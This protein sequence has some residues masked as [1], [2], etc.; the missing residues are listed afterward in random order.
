MSISAPRMKI[1]THWP[2]PYRAAGY[3]LSAGVVAAAMWGYDQ[4]RVP[5]FAPVG[6]KEQIA[7]LKEQ[8][9]KLTAERDQYSSTANA[10]ESRQ[11]MDQSEQHQLETQMKSLENENNK[12]KEDLAFFES[13][14]PV[15][16]NAQGISIRRIKTDMAAANQLHYQLLVMQGG[17]G[18]QNFVGNVQLTVTVLQAGKSVMMVFPEANATDTDKFKVSFKHYQRVEGTL[19]LPDGAVPKAVQARILDRGQI[20]AQQSINL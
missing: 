18:D 13:L 14:L 1:K 10:A 3:V 7:Q 15:D 11:N 4:G 19:T 9:E 20:R 2:W 6:G 12:L 17:K 16:A 8:V 5:G